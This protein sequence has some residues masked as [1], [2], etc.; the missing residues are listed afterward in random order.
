MQD[1]YDTQ[2]TLKRPSY[3]GFRGHWRSRA[4]IMLWSCWDSLA[5]HFKAGA[6][7]TCLEQPKPPVNPAEAP[8]FSRVRTCGTWTQ[9]FNVQHTEYTSPCDYMFE[10]WRRRLSGEWPSSTQSEET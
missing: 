3:L 8:Q 6:A 5:S 4:L 10:N 7:L 1:G 2:T 9:A